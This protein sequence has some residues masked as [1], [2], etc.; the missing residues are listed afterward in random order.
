MQLVDPDRPIAVTLI[1]VKGLLATMQGLL[2]Q[3]D[4]RPGYGVLLRAKEV[5][6][7]GMRFA[8]DTVYLSRKGEVLRVATMAP[9]KIGP[10]MLRAR[11]ILEMRAG[12][13]AR[14]GI[15]PGG[16]LVKRATQDSAGA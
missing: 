3:S 7:L 5:H 6:T 11:H 4:L 16:T 9:G 12:E 14:L 15:V 13:A 10:V 1:E 2:G 8:I